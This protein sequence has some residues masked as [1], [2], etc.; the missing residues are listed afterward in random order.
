MNIVRDIAL[1]DQLVA[2]TTLRTQIIHV[3]VRTK[4]GV[5]S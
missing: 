2:E 3:R 5:F 1:I 4:P